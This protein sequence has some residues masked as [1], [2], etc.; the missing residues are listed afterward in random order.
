MGGS[1]GLVFV[2][3]VS[4]VGSEESLDVEGGFVDR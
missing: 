1:W 4:W 2:G 3:G